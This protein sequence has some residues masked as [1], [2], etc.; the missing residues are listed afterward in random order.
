MNS[1]LPWLCMAIA[2]MAGWLG[3]LLWLAVQGVVILLLIGWDTMLEHW[4]IMLRVAGLYFV[5]VLLQVPSWEPHSMGCQQ[6]GEMS[7]RQGR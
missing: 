5:A 6:R 3:W 1:I 4:V 2:W 7:H